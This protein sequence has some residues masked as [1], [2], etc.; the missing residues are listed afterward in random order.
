MY[1]NS[2]G[3]AAGLAAFLGIWFGHVVV[4]A[5]ERRSASIHLPAVA[6][7]L[8]G[9]LL[10]AGAVLAPQPPLSAALGILGVTAAWDTL[11]FFRQQRRVKRGHAPAN[12][13]NPR[14]R[15]I[16]AEYPDATTLDLLDRQPLG[17]PITPE[18]A[19]ASGEPQEAA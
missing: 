1:L 3:L 5:V 9:L 11:E 19:L 2:T 14:H 16:L 15:R 8:A 18:Q 13:S 7:L 12:P 4:R 10:V 6:F 17:H